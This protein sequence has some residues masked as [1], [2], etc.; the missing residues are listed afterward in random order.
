MRT[1]QDAIN[2]VERYVKSESLRR[3]CLSVGYAME[4][5][6]E[7]FKLRREE[8]DKWFIC[9]VLHDFDWE[10]HPSLEQHPQDGSKILREEGYDE[11][12]VVAILGHGLHTGIARESKMAKTLFA[13]DELSGLICALAKVRAD[14]FSTMDANSV[15]KAMNKKGF[16]SAINREDIKLGIK[17]MGVNEDEH[18]MTVIKA[19]DKHKKEL[20]F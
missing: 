12:I 15:K 14:N 2:L 8:I 6:A 3:H 9:G 16:A 18:F 1:R 7:H 11:D 5:Y 17:E 13:V 4:G 10:I 20:G 19:L